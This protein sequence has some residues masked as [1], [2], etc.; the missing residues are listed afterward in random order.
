M[1]TLKEYIVSLKN[2]I[3]KLDALIVFLESQYVLLSQR[4]IQLEEHNIKML[5]LL[6]SLNDSHTKR[7]AFLVSLGL[8]SG[9]EGLTQLRSKLPSDVNAITTKLLQ[10]LEIKTKTCKMMNERSGQ[11]LSSQRRLM[12]RLTGGE[13]KQA[14][15]EMQL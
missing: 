3:K 9:K 4:D 12:Q 8:P 11:L 1:S 13:N 15:P 6:D 5:K 10:E 14:Y 7:D 2:D